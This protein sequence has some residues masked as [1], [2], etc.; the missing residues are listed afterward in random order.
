M[1]GPVVEAMVGRWGPVVGLRSER[2]E[3]QLGRTVVGSR[4]VVTR[5]MPCDPLTRSN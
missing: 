2:V 1:W 4:V 3:C 5:T